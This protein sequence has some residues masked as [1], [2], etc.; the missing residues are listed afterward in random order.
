[1]ATAKESTE[2]TLFVRTS[3]EELKKWDRSKIYMML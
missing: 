1:M 3:D 2:L